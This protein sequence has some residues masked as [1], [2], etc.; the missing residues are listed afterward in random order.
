MP[1]LRISSVS[2]ARAAHLSQP[3][4]PGEPSVIESPSAAT[5]VRGLVSPAI[6]AL[7]NL[8]RD[9]PVLLDDV[10]AAPLR[11]DAFDIRNLMARMRRELMGVGAEL[12]ELGVGHLDALDAGRVTALTDQVERLRTEVEALGQRL[13]ALVDLPEH[14]LVETDALFPAWGH[15]V[16]SMTT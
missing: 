9:A 3:A 15:C 6:G 8:L 12:L 2:S 11:D 13:D 16:F 7:R 1:Q 5:R 14:G 10:V 4:N